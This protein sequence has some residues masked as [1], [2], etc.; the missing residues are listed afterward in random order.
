MQE[1]KI[2]II[3][4]DFP[5]FTASFEQV[6][7]QRKGSSQ[8]SEI[9]YHKGVAFVHEFQKMIGKDK[10]LKI[11][12]ETYSAPNHF[13]SIKDFEKNIKANNCWNEY[14]KLYEIK[15]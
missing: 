6:L 8:S 5:F 1:E 3:Y 11:I 2:N 15:L 9:I 14:L 10:L 12:R 4:S 7:N 13:V